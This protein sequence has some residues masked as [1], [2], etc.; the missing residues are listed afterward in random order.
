[1]LSLAH[2][3]VL[4][5]QFVR[6]FASLKHSDGCLV[7]SI[8]TMRYFIW[9]AKLACKLQVFHIVLIHDRKYYRILK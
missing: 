9:I 6:E 8:A 4:N 7:Y 3:I 5:F 1:V 2:I